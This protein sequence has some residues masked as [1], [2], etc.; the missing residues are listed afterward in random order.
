MK[1]KHFEEYD[2]VYD[3]NNNLIEVYENQILICRYKYNNHSKITRE[4]NLLLN[5]SIE[6]KYNE[7]D[8]LIQRSFYNYTLN[9]LENVKYSDNFVYDLSNPNL[10]ILYNDESFSYDNNGK[11]NIFRNA[12]LEIT[13][14]NQLI[15][16]DK[17]NFAYNKNNNRTTKIIGDSITKYYRKK[18]KL[19]TQ[20]NGIK[21]KFIYHKNSLAGFKYNHKKYYY[22]K[23]YNNDIVGIYTNKHA[24]I[25]RYAYDCFGNH[26]ILLNDEIFYDLA[27]MNPFR[28]NCKYFDI[29]T[30]LYF[31][32]G[33]Y[34][35]SEINCYLNN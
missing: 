24:L 11:T 5:V 29:E 17:N 18:N 19:I 25:C 15:A 26:K 1:I 9:N 21:L 10:L 7:L 35:D 6:Y 30:G 34:Y 20:D 33:K 4:D 12:K 27:D 16:L 22:K 31:I 8:K 3:E 32:N 23:N 14:D 2:C 28:F 13:K